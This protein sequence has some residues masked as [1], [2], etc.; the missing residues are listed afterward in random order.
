MFNNCSNLTTLDMSGWD[1]SNVTT[2]TSFLSGCSKLVT[3]KVNSSL[4]VTISG[5]NA[6]VNFGKTSYTYSS[7]A[8]SASKST[9]GSVTTIT[10]SR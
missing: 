5:A 4:T 3:W 9:S 1:T 6:T 10:F 8:S 7:G 2:T